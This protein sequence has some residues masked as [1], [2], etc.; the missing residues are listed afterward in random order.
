MKRMAIAVVASLVLVG[1]A[2]ALPII[3]EFVANHTGVDTNEYVEVVDL[4]NTD[5]S[6]FTVV[7]IEGDSTSSLG[8]VDDFTFGL[9]MTD[10][11][12]IWWTGFQNNLLENGT[13][14]IL[15]V[16]GY[17]GA[18]G[19]DID[20]NNDGVIDNPRW[21]AIIDSVAVLD[22]GAGDLTYSP[23]VLDDTLIGAGGFPPGGASLIP[24]GVGPWQANDFAGEGL[25]GFPG[26]TLDPGEA[27]NTPNDFN[28]VPEPS[29]LAILAVG[30]VLG[31][32]RRR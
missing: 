9:G 21:A 7:E 6:D 18:I 5:L 27:I 23:T 11:N 4:P 12:G 31:L 19:D 29:M 17:F 13:K 10:A 16:E 22:G 3:N 26:G 25:P 15:L 14:T 30:T 8:A 32:R 1:S 2:S 24:H 20:T 28:A